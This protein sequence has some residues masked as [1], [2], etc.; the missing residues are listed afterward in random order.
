[1]TKY[2]YDFVNLELTDDQKHMVEMGMAKL[3]H[4]NV[5]VRDA[6]NEK[7]QDGWEPLYPFSVP[8]IW[9]RK[10]VR[11]TRKTSKKVDATS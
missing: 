11:A 8:M 6:I 4:L 3:D 5:M 2:Q 7:A 10:A 9:F 1:M